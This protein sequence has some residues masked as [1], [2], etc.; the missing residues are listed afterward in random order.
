MKAKV[1]YDV[2]NKCTLVRSLEVLLL[3]HNFVET[4]IVPKY[5]SKNFVKISR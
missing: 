4:C 2:V 1:N 5:F 3:Y